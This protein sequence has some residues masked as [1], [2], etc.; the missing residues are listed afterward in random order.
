MDG[1]QT[2]SLSICNPTW[3][4][5]SLRW[6]VYVD[7]GGRQ[8]HAISRISQFVFCPIITPLS[9]APTLR[10]FPEFWE[11]GEP[12]HERGSEFTGPIDGS[13]AEGSI[14]ERAVSIPEQ[15]E[16]LPNQTYKNGNRG[17]FAL[18]LIGNDSS[19]FISRLETLDPGFWDGYFANLV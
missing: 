3:H 7:F 4:I 12:D 11:P 2:S 5:V 16:P 14:P 18:P 10:H 6:K 8:T 9:P 17:V 1:Y 19:C 13:R 15:T